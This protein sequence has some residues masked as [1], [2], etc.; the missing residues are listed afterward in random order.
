LNVAPESSQLKMR[1]DRVRRVGP[2]FENEK[3]I[4]RDGVT[5]R[6]EKALGKFCRVLDSSVCA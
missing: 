3:I 4:R 6:E 2:E 1:A 5:F